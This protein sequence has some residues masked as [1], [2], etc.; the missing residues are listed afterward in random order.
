MAMTPEGRVKAAVKKLLKERGIWHYM[1]VQNGMGV[2]GIPDIIACF[3]GYFL[4]IET[5]APNKKPTTAEQRWKKATPN[6]QN[7]ITGINQSGG[8]AIV[9]DD[10]NQVAN[11]LYH[12][13]LAR[14]RRGNLGGQPEIDDDSSTS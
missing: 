1:P 11:V 7:Q 4:A 14:A 13:E 5:K 10:V 9:V 3:G 2:V 12:I 6:Q 8:V